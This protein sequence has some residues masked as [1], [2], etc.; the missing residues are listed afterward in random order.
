MRIGVAGTAVEDVEATAPAV[1]DA[2]ADADTSSSARHFFAWGAIA[3]LATTALVLGWASRGT[4]GHLVYVIDD[5]AIHLGIAENLAHHGTWGVVPGHYE[6]A[7]S[8]PLWTL[9]LAAWVKLVPSPSSA[10]PLFLNLFAGLAVIATFAWVQRVLWP[11]RRRPLDIVAV[12]A[13]VSVILF[14]PGLAYT[15]MEHSLQ[16]ALLL[17]AVVLFH[18]RAMGRSAFGPAWLPYLLLALATLT[19][20]ETAFVALGIALALLAMTGPLAAIRDAPWERLRQPLL[21]LASSGAP[22]AGFALVNRLMGQGFLPNSVLAKSSV[23]AGTTVVGN[24]LDRFSSD[25]LLAVLTGTMLVALLLLGSRRRQWSFPAVVVCISVALHVLLARMG[26]Y[27]RYQAYL[28]ALAVYAAMCLLADWLPSL[29]RRS[30][31]RPYLVPALV[32]VSL[33]FAGV[34]MSATFSISKA[35]D[36]TY[37]QRFQAALFLAEYYDGQA[38]ATGELGYIALMHDGPLTDF[39]GL[40]DHEVLQAWQ[41]AGE[42]PQAPYWSRLAQERGFEVVAAYPVTLRE[43]TP[44]EWVPVATW[45]LDRKTHT[46]FWPQFVFYATTPEA[47]RPL[48]ENLRDFEPRLPADVKVTMNELAEMR[49]DQIRDE[50]PLDPGT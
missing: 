36:D 21:V 32:A 34:K 7:S 48:Q 22:L 5:P 13:L 46:A 6:S 50:L 27:E 24:A 31:I 12:A 1:I 2:A 47:V 49:A 4:G 41:R 3:Y 9:L 39:F 43:D 45:D 26:W 33:L 40:G 11:S 20:F 30:P 15:G 19:R 37:A 44:Q 42:R 28:I 25:A 23:P 16:I 38:I 10:A 29:E 35:V 14:L 17:P 8:S 18:R